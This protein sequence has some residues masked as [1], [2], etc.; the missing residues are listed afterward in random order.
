MHI[1]CSRST[2]WITWKSTLD[3]ILVRTTSP[4]MKHWTGFLME[5][6]YEHWNSSWVHYQ[7]HLWCGKGV[8]YRDCAVPLWCGKDRFQLK[9]T[10]QDQAIVSSAF[11]PSPAWWVDSTYRPYQTV[12]NYMTA[13]RLHASVGCSHDTGGGCRGCRLHA[14]T[15]CRRLMHTIW[16][17]IQ[18][19]AVTFQ[20]Q[21][22]CLRYTYVS[23]KHMNYWSNLYWNQHV[24]CT[25]LYPLTTST[26]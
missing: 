25:T 8:H 23:A 4:L 13:C 22:S 5:Q 26:A 18:S 10:Y 20:L 9:A 7:C 6:I 15:A 24:K 11:L 16:V 14:V 21:L 2:K 17:S 3:L 19:K 1:Q 12:Y